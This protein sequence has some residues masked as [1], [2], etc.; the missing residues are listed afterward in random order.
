[1][2]AVVDLTITN[3][4]PSKVCA[5]FFTESFRTYSTPFIVTVSMFSPLLL[6]FIKSPQSAPSR[7]CHQTP[8]EPLWLERLGYENPVQLPLPTPSARARFPNGQKVKCQKYL[9]GLRFYL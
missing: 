1:G 9:C 4:L 6:L 7:A 2:L 3:G 5:S 8:W